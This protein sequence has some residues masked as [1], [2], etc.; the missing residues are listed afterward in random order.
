MLMMDP[1]PSSVMPG[2]TA[3]IPSRIPVWLIETT[4]S[5]SS[6]PMSATPAGEPMPALLTSTLIG[7]QLGSRLAITAS[8]SSLDETSACR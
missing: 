7:P 5:H 6:R 4:R 2:M 1:E 3:W 8:Q